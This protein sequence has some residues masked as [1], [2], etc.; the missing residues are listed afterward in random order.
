M[1]RA[2]WELEDLGLK[3]NELDIEQE[4]TGEWL[5]QTIIDDMDWGHQIDY[6]RQASIYKSHQRTR[7][8]YYHGSSEGPKSLNW[9]HLIIIFKN[10]HIIINVN[11]WGWTSQ[12]S[13]TYAQNYDRVLEE[14]ADK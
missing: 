10:L 3:L 7:S 9:N 5:I 4:A 12:K 13:Q 6:N 1:N 14:V 8:H 2:N 11:D